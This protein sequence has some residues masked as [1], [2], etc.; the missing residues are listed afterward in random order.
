MDHRDL[1]RMSTPPTQAAGRMRIVRT[2]AELRAAL[3]PRRREGA[4][5][6]LVPT[7]GALHEG[8]LSLI[9]AARRRCDV[10]VVS[11]FVNPAQFDERTDLDR[12]PRREREDAE[13]AAAAGADVLF[14]PT[15]EEVYPE[16]FATFV[17]VVG[18]TDRLEGAVRG[19]GHFRGVTT[20]VTKLLNMVGP[21][22]AFFGQKDA[23]QL[24][25]IRRLVADLDL[26][27]RIEA[28]PIVREADG[29]AM[30]SRNALLGAEG[31]SRARALPAALAAARQRVAAGEGAPSAICAAA[32]EEL[33]ARGVE[34][35]YVELVDPATFEPRQRLD[36]PA[37]LLLAARVA[38]VRLIDNELLTS[39]TRPQIP[40]EEAMQCSA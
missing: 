4:S 1:H 24:A 7:M 30:S 29:V 10:V 6:G 18:L 21:D 33:R 39:V 31:R 28:M 11:L 40:E 23:Q 5:V 3:R 37:L 32:R 19:S 22:F 12:Y 20:V 34:P 13:R 35:E 17:E 2:V 16:G 8:H 25:V 9:R 36:G 15:A 38:G 14:A 26:P 27:V